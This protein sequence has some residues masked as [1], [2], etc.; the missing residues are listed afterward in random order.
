MGATYGKPTNMGVN[1]LNNQRSLQAVAEERDGCKC[2]ALWMLNSYWVAR[3]S[4][5]KL[6]EVT[7]V[8]PFHKTIHRDPSD[9][10]ICKPD[11]MQREM[12]GLTSGGRK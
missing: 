4:T 9:R 5:Y 7:T 12:R 1:Q 3:D 11:A 8:D 6:F 10:W 2:K